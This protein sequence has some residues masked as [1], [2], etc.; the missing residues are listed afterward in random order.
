MSGLSA[1]EINFLFP[2]SGAEVYPN[3]IR[4][5]RLSRFPRNSTRQA[6]EVPKRSEIKIL[7][8]RSLS[9]LTFLVMT[10][11][12]RFASMLTLTYGQNYPIDGRRVKESINKFL[13]GMRRKF[14]GFEYIWFLEFQRRGAPHLHIVTTLSNTSIARRRVMAKIWLNASSPGAYWY[15]DLKT[16]EL[17]HT[18]QTVYGVHCHEKAWEMIRSPD[19]ASRYVLKYALK[20]SQKIVP[21]SYRNVGRFWGKSAGVTPGDGEEID[22]DESDMREYLKSM[23]NTQHDKPVLPKLLLKF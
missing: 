12:T 18:A 13:V 11:R 17:K 10:T 16:R 3:I 23:G 22:V 9:R 5:K 20:K 15:S 21:R 2:V 6:E 4:L 7:S 8:R 14:Q 19:G 1:Q